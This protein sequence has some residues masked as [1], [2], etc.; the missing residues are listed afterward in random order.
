MN[1]FSL[2]VRAPPPL[3]RPSSNYLSPV[4]ALHSA[5]LSGDRQIRRRAGTHAAVVSRP[6]HH[7]LIVGRVP[8]QRER[9]AGQPELFGRRPPGPRRL[10]LLPE[11]LGQRAASSGTI[12]Q[13]SGPGVPAFQ[14]TGGLRPATPPR[15][16]RLARNRGALSPPRACRR[17]SPCFSLLLSNAA[18]AASWL[19]QR[20]W[21]G[22]AP[23]CGAP[24]RRRQL[25][26]PLAYHCPP[27]ERKQHRGPRSRGR[28]APRT[29]RRAP[30]DLGAG[31]DPRRQEQEPRPGERRPGPA[32]GAL[33]A[34]CLHPAAAAA[35]RAAESVAP[36]EVRVWRGGCA[37]A[38]EP[39]SEC[40]SG[41]VGRG[42]PGRRWL[43]LARLAGPLRS[44]LLALDRSLSRPK[45]DSKTQE[46]LINTP[47]VLS[48]P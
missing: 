12:G 33:R 5:L 28:G 22:P 21:S 45:G 48:P 24:P 35:A 36:A 25:L 3:P 40:V 42:R 2:Q 31:Q 11:T 16:P 34:R 9:G 41:G 39:E 14:G 30:S 46:K 13:G 37:R 4:P 19:G 27:E 1:L 26:W 38:G 43:G 15:A 8:G 23:Q 10:H 20:L 47:S 18:A 7:G 6:V 32:C 29:A 44:S 17:R